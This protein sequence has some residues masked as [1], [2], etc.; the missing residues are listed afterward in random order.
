ML[1]MQVSPIIVPPTNGFAAHGAQRSLF[2]NPIKRIFGKRPMNS[3]EVA[4]HRLS[5]GKFAFAYGVVFY[6]SLARDMRIM[7]R[8]NVLAVKLVSGRR[9][10]AWAVDRRTAAPGN[11]TLTSAQWDGEMIRNS[12]RMGRSKL[13]Y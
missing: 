3:P 4:L 13:M 11:C 8:A 6:M 5:I 1:F 12:L 2:S 9:A 7:L 10:A